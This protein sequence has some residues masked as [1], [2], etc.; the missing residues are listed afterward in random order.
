VFLAILGFP[1]VCAEFAIGRGSGKGAARAFE[2]LEKKGSKW[3]YF[4]SKLNLQYF[5]VVYLLQYSA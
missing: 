3:H 1:I 5:T 2:V 4:L